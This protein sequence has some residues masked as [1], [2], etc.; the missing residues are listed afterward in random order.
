MAQSRPLPCQ[1]NLLR[2][3]RHKRRARD[4]GKQVTLQEVFQDL[5]YGARML[6][7]SPGFSAVAIL[8]LA[9]GIGAN[10]TLFSVVNGVLLN[11]LPFSQPDP[12]VSLYESKPNFDNGAITYPNFLDWQRQN[13]SFVNIAGHRLTNFSLTG[14]SEAERVRAAQISAGFFP[15][16]GVKPLAGRLFSADEDRLGAQPVALIGEGLWRRKFGAAPDIIGR[17]LILD[18]SAHT[19]VG[20]IPSSFRLQMQNFR[21]AD[22]YTPIGQWNYQWFLNR[23]T[24]QGMDAIGRLKPGVTLQQ[25]RADMAGITRELAVEYPKADKGVGASVIPLKEAAVWGLGPLLLL[26]LGAVGFVLLIACVNVANLLLARSTGRTREF[27]IRAALGASKPRVIRQLLT[28][29]ILLAIA[30]GSLGVLLATLGVQG[31]LQFA[32]RLNPEG[33]MPRAEEIGLNNHVLLFTLAI[34]LFVGSDNDKPWALWYEV[35]SNYLKA[36]GIPLLHGRFFT[37]A[38]DLN[39]QRVAVIDSTFAEKYFP[40]EDAVG[41]TIVDDYVGPTVV[42]GV[43][44]HV[45]HWGPGS[46]M[47]NR[48]QAQMYFPFAQIRVKAMSVVAS[49]FGVAVRSKGDPLSVMGSIRTAVSRMNSQQ[50]IYEVST[51]QETIA[52]R[53]AP[54]QFVM[55]LLSLFAGLALV[56]ASVGIYGVVSY[57]VGQR[58]HEVGIR[59]ALGAQQKDVLCLVVGEGLKMACAGVALGLLAAF[60][61]TRVMANVLNS[62]DP[63]YPRILY[64]VSATDPL[65]FAVVAAFLATVAL[66]ACYVPARRAMRLDPIIALRHE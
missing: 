48:L 34:A 8:T 54:Q 5:K 66:A 45:N 24:A 62:A 33:G 2:G 13:H 49:G 28:E 56:L 30:G 64:R 25:A 12:L 3:F 65:T 20:I 21:V 37:T 27:A 47:E 14:T 18:G 29:S 55:V 51:M 9:L 36:M 46:E 43:I 38:D 16:L 60:A 22:V 40:N 59:I 52:N 4:R 23:A 57:L 58:T 53:L 17:S 7:R 44:G 41:K 19:V 11:P 6:L 32:Q 39:S 61:L 26:L 1:I 10:T 31:V 63:D 15:I 35:D 42:V 50:I